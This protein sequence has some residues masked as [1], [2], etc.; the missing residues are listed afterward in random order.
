MSR[1]ESSFLAWWKRER[2]A[3]QI[4][5]VR[6]IEARGGVCRNFSYRD[7]RACPLDCSLVESDEVMLAKAREWLK[8]NA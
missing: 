3:L 2:K 8:A 4:A 6:E 7:C 5:H 1:A